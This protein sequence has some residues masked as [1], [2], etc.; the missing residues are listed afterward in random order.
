MR[1][2][3][4]FNLLIRETRI[5]R[6]LTQLQLATKLGATS[7]TVSF[8]DTE[9]LACAMVKQSLLH[10]ADAGNPDY[11]PRYRPRR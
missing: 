10:G 8:V 1:D 7:C 6:N 4:P 5:N 3:T 2:E 9:W 11:R